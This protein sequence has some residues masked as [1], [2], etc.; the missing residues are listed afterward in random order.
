[1]IEIDERIF[2]YVSRETFH[3]YEIYFSELVSWNK[4]LSLVQRSTLE[5]F[6]IRHILDSLQ[7]I[8]HIKKEDH[9]IDI[10]AGAG[11]PG[12]VLSIAGIENITL[13]ESNRKKCLFLDEIKR[14]TNAKAEILN[15]RVE[16]I[17]SKQYNLV[18]SRACSSLSD[19]L[20]YGS[21]V[22]R[23]TKL[24]ILAHK[25]RT[26]LNEIEEAKKKW[27]FKWLKIDSITSNDSVILK[28]MDINKIPD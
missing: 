3:K 27:D 7:L 17:T 11:F 4:A 1:M 19:L 12:M 14:R 28:I 15:M 8:P 13:C 24:E 6:W 2:N 9:I 23:E 25:G 26:Y 21:F 16:E 18:L 10:G 22:S 20:H 5:H